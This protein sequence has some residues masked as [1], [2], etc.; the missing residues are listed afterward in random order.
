MIARA[1]YGALRLD[2]V[3]SH[4]GAMV[5]VMDDISGDTEYHLPW[6]LSSL[7]M[8]ES[9]PTLETGTVVIIRGL[10]AKPELNG[11]AATVESFNEESG[12]YNVKLEAGDIFALKPEALRPNRPGKEKGMEAAC[13][14][15]APN[16]FAE[17]TSE[18]PPPPPNLTLITAPGTISGY[19]NVTYIKT[20]QKYRVS[21]WDASAK[22]MVHLGALHATAE[23]AAR[24]WA[25]HAWRNQAT[26][27]G[28][29]TDHAP[30]PPPTPMEIAKSSA[31]AA[32]APAASAGAAPDTASGTASM[33]YRHLLKGRR[34]SVWWED[35][36]KWYDGTVRDYSAL[37]EHLVLYD[38]GEQRQ[39]KLD[40]CSW[41]LLAEPS[42]GSGG[43]G[44]NRRGTG[45]GRGA[46]KQPAAE[47][48]AR[49]RGAGGRGPG[50]RAQA[51]PKSQK[52]PQPPTLPLPS[53]VVTP[54]CS[55]LEGDAMAALLVIWQV[56]RIFGPRLCD[57]Y[58]PP[59]LE[60]LHGALIGSA[61][62]A[63]SDVLGELHMILLE[64]L[65]ALE[66]APLHG[67][68][69]AEALRA[70]I[71]ARAS[72]AGR[73]AEQMHGY[74][75]GWM[76][77]KHRSASGHTYK[78]YFAPDGRR[79][80]TLLE[81]RSALEL[82]AAGARVERASDSA[83]RV[84]AEA[85]QPEPRESQLTDEPADLLAI[86]VRCLR[87]C[88]PFLRSSPLVWPEV[89]RLAAC[90]WRARESPHHDSEAPQDGESAHAYARPNIQ[91]L[92]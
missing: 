20:S 75:S 25:E 91:P 60:Q 34:V 62:L 15:S 78:E 29:T 8:S 32:A 67:D 86:G 69:Q 41:K 28:D 30:R 68:E 42:R 39:E 82:M 83:A 56:A 38:D 63:H 16:V 49:V 71:S 19:K 35:D 81:S 3:V 11:K 6:A 58:T 88:L 65:L 55:Q 2:I 84:D 45:I 80:R 14:M 7:S 73:G 23:E 77:I 76:A 5:S 9:S 47:S 51:Q 31:S 79:F 33:V 50:G 57:K 72:A 74:P 17:M 54:F 18:A 90:W 44:G 53:S 36:R 4:F 48:A 61:P 85:H 46:G 70:D 59:T 92:S 52:Q 13:A 1:T 64:R 12:R 21:F 27:I 89:L 40:T 66:D 43:R 87:D 37:G 24:V 26:S 22:K 10:K